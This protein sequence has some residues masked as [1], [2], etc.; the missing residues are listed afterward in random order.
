MIRAGHLAAVLKRVP[1]K[2]WN[3]S[4]WPE[5]A[6]A[7]TGNEDAIVDLIR[8][9]ASLLRE[10]TLLQDA[11]PALLEK[12]CPLVADFGIV[13]EYGLKL[14]EYHI[15][16]DNYEHASIMMKHG[17]RLHCVKERKHVPIELFALERSILRCRAVVVALTRVKR[18]GN[19]W[20]WDKFLLA[21]I[22]RE[23]W[24]TRC[25]EEWM[26]E[27]D[28]EAYCEYTESY[29]EYKDIKV[30]LGDLRVRREELHSKLQRLQKHFRK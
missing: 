10:T 13:A 14:L 9:D 24:G 15:Q 23:V 16:A 12:L 17:A 19:L 22:A 28:W 3:K 8:E 21:L 6:L 4:V 26:G 18:V 1:R 2:Q 7:H 30:T 11:W 25:E 27:G 20:Q 5:L 29:D